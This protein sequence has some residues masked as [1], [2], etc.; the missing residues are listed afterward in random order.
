MSSDAAVVV[1]DLC[2]VYRPDVTPARRLAKGLLGRPPGTES[3]RWA[4]RDVSFELRRGETLG[5][6]GRNGC[7]KSTLLEIIAGIL[8]PTSGFVDV[9]GEL[10]ALLELGAGFSPELTGRENVFVYGALLGMS[11]ADVA[12]RFDEIVDFAELGAYIDEPVKYYS[13]G[14]F[15]RLAFAVAVSATPPILV[16][17]EALAVGDEAFQR[18]CFAR[19]ETLKQS[20]VSLL[21][22][23]HAAGTVLELCDRALLLDAGEAI[24][25][26]TPRDVVRHYHRLIYAPV[27]EQDGIREAIQTYAASGSEALAEANEVRP[28]PDRT[29]V[30]AVEA[31][32]EECY[33]VGL[34]SKSRLEYA[35]RGAVISAPC[36]L[37]AGGEPRNVLQRG[38]T[39]RVEFDVA[40]EEDAFNVRFG[41][42]IKTIIG[43]ELG[44]LVSAAPGAGLEHV[45]TGTRLHASL[46]FCARLAP[47]TYFAN[48]GVVGLRE[49]GEIFLHRIT[50]ALAF[51][52]VQERAN[53]LTG[54]VD[55]SSRATVIIS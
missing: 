25:T 16:I 31:L 51:R 35:K 33:D 41:I 45:I 11:K 5:V 21:F 18:R 37:S 24:L 52:V 53:S 27:A 47:E 19:I 7:G 29:D 3:G 4:L 50:D 15:V 26:S 34:T 6:M 14:M 48:V 40:F 2:K 13:S 39:Y 32:E 36:I 20:G 1:E 42:L 10:A 46:P 54:S 55:F 22:V 28:A 43:T 44:G 17:D 38:G 12:K 49:G 9:R 30:V 23:S 8:S